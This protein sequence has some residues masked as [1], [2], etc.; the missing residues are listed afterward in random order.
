M[1][2]GF[3]PKQVLQHISPIIYHPPLCTC[4]MMWNETF[5]TCPRI[6]GYS[7]CWKEVALVTPHSKESC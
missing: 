4:Y 1:C 5:P 7:P 3:L 6:G 2:L